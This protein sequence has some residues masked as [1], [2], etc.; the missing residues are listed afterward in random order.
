MNK[1][2]QLIIFITIF[3]VIIML[4]LGMLPSLSL[5]FLPKQ[6]N[7]LFLTSSP[8]N[9][10]SLYVPS[11]ISLTDFYKTYGDRLLGNKKIHIISREQWGANDNYANPEVIND[12][13]KRVYCSNS[14][15]DAENYFSPLEYW[16]SRELFL[17]Y[18]KNFKNY[19][20]LFLQAKKKENGVNYQYLPVEQI[21][22]HH[23]AGRFT[24]S[25]RDSEKEVRRIYF[26]HAVQRRWQDIG[27]H[28]LIDGAGHIFE[29]T[30]GG[31]YSVGAHT[32]MHNRATVSIALM[33]DFR[34]G[35]DKITPAMSESLGKLVRYLAD[36]YHWNLSK[37][38]F[39][40]RKKDYSGREWTN[41]I[42]KGHNEV[43]YRLKRTECPGVNDD[44][45]REIIYPY[46]FGSI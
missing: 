34:P 4:I 12:M 8:K 25:L 46:L 14:S 43:D 40:L 21:I 3:S 45:L 24:T 7:S 38:M 19:D 36:Q 5:S 6:N 32:F 2:Q 31:K 20:D 37:K 13:C 23:T 18:Q 1:R 11:Y 15:Y 26:A 39:Y 16:R 42:V 10:S 28:Y 41:K 22:I 30:L 9:R 44:Y 33:G 17:N 27:Y 35:H 29:G